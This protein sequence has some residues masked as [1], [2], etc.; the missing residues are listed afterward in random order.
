MSQHDKLAKVQKKYGIKE[1]TDKLPE[2]DMTLGIDSKKEFEV[3]K[4]LETIPTEQQL[5]EII[6]LLNIAPIQLVR[7]NEKIWKEEFKDDDTGEVVSIERSQ[8]VRVDNNWEW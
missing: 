3:V 4:Y 6:A 8:V 2:E 1:N 5:T 7:K